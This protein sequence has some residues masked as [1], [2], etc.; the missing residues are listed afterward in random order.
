MASLS[1]ETL[2]LVT[3]MLRALRSHLAVAF[4]SEFTDDDQRV[5]RAIDVEGPD[6][7]IVVG[8]GDPIIPDASVNAEALQIPATLALGVGTHM[9]VPIRLSSGEVFGTFCCFSDQVVPDVGDADLATM[10]RLAASVAGLLE[11]DRATADRMA[12]LQS[13]YTD[14]SRIG[15]TIAHDLKTP[16][17]S[18]LGFSELLS[19]HYGDTLGEKGAEWLA[20]VSSSARYVCQMIDDIAAFANVGMTSEPP[21]HVDLGELVSTVVQ[22]LES[23]VEAT[24]ATITVGELPVVT[25]YGGPLRQLFQNLLAN[26]MKFTQPGGK[27]N[28]ALVAH[29]DGD[30]WITTVADNGIGIADSERD[31][32]FEPFVRAGGARDYDGTGLGLAVARRVAHLQGG[33]IEALPDTPCGTIMRVRPGKPA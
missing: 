6:C 28:V 13:R 5:F 9:S 18:V 1:D 21:G 31:R 14:A 7:P 30:A 15:P 27:P 3:E 22:A 12:T 32:V 4:V 8:G 25:G 19:A 33:T 10:R 16:L 23:Q 2:A 20:M 11:R 26:A 24:A 29:A 17:V